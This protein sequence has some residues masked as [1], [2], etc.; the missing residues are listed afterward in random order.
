MSYCS[1]VLIIGLNNTLTQDRLTLDLN[2]DAAS[3]LR[4]VTNT[5]GHIS[6][7]VAN[8][9]FQGVNGNPAISTTTATQVQA[10]GKPYMCVMNVL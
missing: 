7:V 9:D 2:N 1:Q 5:T 8:S 3:R 10:I 4:S 6:I